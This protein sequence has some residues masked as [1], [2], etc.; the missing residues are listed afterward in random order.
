MFKKSC[1]VF[2]LVLLCILLASQPCLLRGQS[3]TDVI[4]ATENPK[5]WIITS[6]SSTYQLVVT[7]E[8]QVMPVYY[9][10]AQH[11]IPQKPI[12]D[13]PGI[14]AEIPV[15]GGFANKTPVI[16]A[17]FYDNN[18]D[19]DL[20]F[21]RAE[22]STLNGYPLLSIV[23][24]DRHYQFEVTSFIRVIP[25]LDLLE[26]WIEVR[27]LGN[28]SIRL[29]NL[30]SGSIS[31]PADV[32]ELNYVSGY[33]GHEYQPQATLLTTGTKTIQVK[34]FKSYGIPAFILSRENNLGDV[35]GN[36]W[37]GTLHY[38]GNWRFDFDKDPEGSIQVAGGI[39]F[40]DTWWNL[41]TGDTFSTPIL[42]FGF[43]TAGREGVARTLSKYE[44]E[45][46]MKKANK[47]RL[48]PVLYNSWYATEFAVNEKDQLALAKIAKSLGVEMF[49]IDDGWFEGR[50]NDKGGLGDWTVD[51]K[52]FPNGLNPLIKKINDLG[53]DFGLW[54][55]PEMVNP[56]SNLFRKHPD[57]VFNFPN[58][59]AN[60]VRNQ[61]MLN[62]ARE[63]VYD[64]LYQSLHTLLKD[65]NIKY[66]KWDMNRPLSEPGWPDAPLEM[67]REVRIRYVANLYK[68]I[69]T[70]RKEFPEVWFENCSS[71][72]GRVDL[73][74][75]SRTDVFWAS[76][77]TDP[78][79]R[80]FIQYSYLGYLPANTMISW[81]THEDAHNT[82]PSLEYKFD[83]AMSGVLG[84]GYDITKWSDSQKSLA[85]KKIAEYK[86]LR[87]LINNGIVHRLVS[88]Y[89]SE[90][91]ALEFVSTD[92][93]K[94]A[95]FFYNLGEVMHG[96]TP[97][98]RNSTKVQLRDLDAQK[99]YK[100]SLDGVLYTGEYLMKVGV[101]WPLHGSYTSK[102]ATFD[103]ID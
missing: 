13:N 90:K 10:P 45:N 92:S 6:H 52:K 24:A 81:T 83:V 103:R 84:V 50:V 39:N 56:N 86:E 54:I 51:L 64:F 58:R 102:I 95:V 27:N 42:T 66:L 21:E 94:A 78:I 74:M 59:T 91:S 20:Q 55:E 96:S 99:R 33:W 70:L 85:A 57:W 3:R 38:S 53:L 34:D 28:K 65:H 30:Q 87:P 43:T 26:K 60:E 22:I 75:L 49:V 15:R 11:G 61:L 7:D 36:A 14:P 47:D 69:D 71:G 25:S 1:R 97:G 80:I 8:G 89:T 82:H 37:F 67:Q 72:G 5:G 18:R 62:L 40:W 19:I 31:L 32:Y 44:K 79:D 41:K 93:G 63:D 88:P 4:T 73:G 46:V 98:S 2:G 16:E 100:S 77:N 9:G 29:E 68:L 101:A 76:D 35:T 12:G 23:Q 48:R 17:I